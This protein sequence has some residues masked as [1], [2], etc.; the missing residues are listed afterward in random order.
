M[1]RKCC[2]NSQMLNFLYFIS[3]F[4]NFISKRS[5]MDFKLSIFF[6]LF[7][8]LFLS[9]DAL[10]QKSNLLNRLKRSPQDQRENLAQ[11][12]S[13]FTNFP[14]FKLR[15]CP[16]PKFCSLSRPLKIR[17]CVKENSPSYAFPK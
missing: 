10:I 17:Y 2:N 12:N 16:P 13:A 3:T 6:A 15:G 4:Q 14:K 11:C 1:I 8:L 9:S 7:S 5:K